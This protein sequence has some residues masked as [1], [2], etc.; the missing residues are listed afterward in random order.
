MTFDLLPFFAYG[1]RLFQLTI[2]EYF[3]CTWSIIQAH[4]ELAF[5]T[6]KKLCQV[7]EILLNKIMVIT[8]DFPVRWIEIEE[9][10]GL[11]CQTCQLGELAA[12]GKLRECA[13]HCID[14]LHGSVSPNCIHPSCIPADNLQKLDAIL[15]IERRLQH[16]ICY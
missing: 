5:Y 6:G 10:A 16:F 13:D 11:L 9:G 8:I 12:V 2:S 7:D 14:D 4:N 15:G 3:S 1:V